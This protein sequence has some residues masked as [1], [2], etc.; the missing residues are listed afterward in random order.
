VILDYWM[1]GM[2]GTQVASELKR[3]KPSV[4]IIVLS[5]MMELPGEAAGLVDEWMI[6]GSTRAEELLNSIHTLLEQRR[7]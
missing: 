4:P 7:A 3:I 5:G 1:S 6:K 2:K